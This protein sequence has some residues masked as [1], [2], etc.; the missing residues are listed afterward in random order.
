MTELGLMEEGNGTP[1]RQRRHRRKKRRRGRAF[2]AVVLSLAVVGGIAYGLYYGATQLFGSFSEWFGEAEDYP[3]PGSGEVTVTIESGS[4]LRNIGSTLVD[5]GVVASQGAFVAAAD[6]NPEASSIQPGTYTLRREM[7]AADAITAMLEATT[8]VSRAAVPEGLRVRQTV[9][10]LAE[11]TEFAAE[12]LQAAVDSAE[13][14]DYAE[15]DAE[16]FLFPATYDLK[17]DSDAASLINAMINRFGQAAEDVGLANAAQA[18]D[19]TIREMVTIASIVQREVRR[20]E[21]MPRVADVIYN[22][23]SGACNANGVPEGRLQMDSTVHYAIDD[24][25]TVFTS[26]ED[27]QID[28]PYNTYRVS[29]L[30]P[31]PIA[32]PGEEALS[33]VVNPAGGD[34]CYFVAIDLET[35]ETAFAVTEEDHAAN[36]ARLQE[37]CTTSDLC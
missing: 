2:I 4:S 7:R 8:V 37:Y 10:R 36:V 17:Q 3:G 9:D 18:R 30:P 35:G 19:M 15:G 32:S 29:G 26:S 16:G 20:T 5:A 1:R 21:D 28:S 31:G 22:R 33:A 11:E 23:L 27:R 6:E 13:L 25:S 12:D 24:Y 14:P 34:D